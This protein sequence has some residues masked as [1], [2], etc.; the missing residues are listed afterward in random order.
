MNSCLNDIPVFL[1]QG[2]NSKKCFLCKELKHLSEYAPDHRKY[3]LKPDM[4]TCKVCKK[5]DFKRAL[6]ELS[7][8]RF[9]FVEQKFEVIKFENKEKVI[10]WYENN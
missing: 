1:T 9:N 6:V 5:C 4:N 3:Q 10:E 2:L 7:V 8:V